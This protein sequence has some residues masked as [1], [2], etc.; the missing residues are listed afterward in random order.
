MKLALFL[1]L[2]VLLP[3]TFATSIGPEISMEGYEIN[4]LIIFAVVGLLI[5]LLC[6]IF[7]ERNVSKVASKTGDD[8]G[9]ALLAIASSLP[10][11]VIAI[12]LAL[13]GHTEIIPIYVLGATIANLS[14]VLGLLAFIKPL[15]R[16]K[17]FGRGV[18]AF[19]FM[20]LSLSLVFLYITKSKIVIGGSVLDKTDGIA[21]IILFVFYVLLL[22]L[23]KGEQAHLHSKH[24]FLEA[25]MALVYGFLV[26]WFANITVKAFMQISLIY[27]LPAVI[28]G[29]VIA[30]IGA[31]LP[32]L[33][34]GIVCLFKKED[35]TLFANLITSAVVN[36]NL[37]L[38]IAAIITGKIIFDKFLLRFQI[39][40]MLLT[41]FLAVYLMKS[42]KGEK[43]LTRGEGI[44]LMGV[45][46]AYLIILANIHP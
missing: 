40:F 36:F 33:A 43:G 37:G 3:A 27:D 45:F 11:L 14:L 39:P 21:L 8:I 42:I 29:S 22:K 30:V 34:V 31:S 18:L 25:I 1:V 7:L 32:E 17:S 23:F 20:I 2:L 12:T 24:L 13:E 35:E 41:L 26:C 4:T 46:A 44:V 19:V 9:T 5:T 10:L 6:A 28:I 16:G 38:G 15:N